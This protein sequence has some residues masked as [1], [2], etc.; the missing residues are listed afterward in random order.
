MHFMRWL[1][2]SGWVVL[3]LL[4]GPAYM[5]TFGNITLGADWQ[6]ADRSSAG[7][8]P[9]AAATPEAVIQIYSARAFSWRGIFAVHTWI[10]TK[11]ENAA[12]YSVHEVL[13]W[14]SYQ[15]LPVV[16]STAGIPDRS[17]YGATPEILVDLRGAQ[18][19]ELIPQIVEAVNAYPYADKYVMW[20]GPNSNTFTAWVARQVPE[21]RMDLPTTAVGKDFLGTTRLFDITPS[22][23]GGQFSAFG[24]LGIAAGLREGLEVN[25]LGFNLGID[26]LG[27]A[28]KLPGIGRVGQASAT[29][30]AR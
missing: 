12:N 14:R 13:G 22:G 25:L 26:P 27:L 21:L 18:A 6:T 4:L 7:I 15:G 8:A 30:T 28:I 16:S 17:W 11:P 5:G 2:H 29:G 24:L 10:A 3:L 19:A 9:N 1:K 20:P 23:T